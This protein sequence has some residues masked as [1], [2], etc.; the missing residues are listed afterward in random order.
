MVTDFVPG[1]TGKSAPMKIPGTAACDPTFGT[2]SRCPMSYSRPI[3]PGAA[4]LE[5]PCAEC[6]Q[7]VSPQRAL[8]ASGI[9]QIATTVALSSGRGAAPLPA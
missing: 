2:R 6:A 9:A 8:S 3:Q 4:R 7:P 5:P 1:I